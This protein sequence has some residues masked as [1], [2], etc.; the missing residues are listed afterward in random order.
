MIDTELSAEK[1]VPFI[2]EQHK[3]LSQSLLWKLQR[4]FFEEH[5][6]EA[7]RLGEVPHYITNNPF[8]AGA[9]AKVVIGFLK[10]CKNNAEASEEAAFKLD[11]KQPVYIVELGAGSG[12]F[13]FHFLKQFLGLLRG[14]VFSDI[15]VK[16][17]MT[18]FSERTLDYWRTHPWLQP[19]VE[20][21]LLDFA[22]FD[23]EQ[24]NEPILTHCGD[25]LSEGTVRNPLIILAN[26]FFDSI[27]QDAFYINQGYIYESLVT[28]TCPQMQ[29]DTS[30]PDLLNTVE[31]TYDH[32]PVN[33]DYYHDSDFDQILRDY[34]DS[35]EDTMLLFPCTAVRC[36]RDLAKLSNGRLLLLSADKG[37]SRKE[38]VLGRGCPQFKVHG[39]LSMMVNYHAIGQYVLNQGCAVL[40][41]AHRHKS[42][43]VSAF[44]LGLPPIAAVETNQAYVE[45]IERF[46]PDDFYNL[47][48][49]V[50][51]FYDSLTL[52]QIFAYLR[53][54]GWDANIFLGCFPTLLGLV[55]SLSKLEQQEL[56]RVILQ[57]WDTYYPIGEEK[58]LAF[59]LGMLLY[60]MA[61]YPEALDYF[62]QSLL[63]YGRDISTVYNMGMCH[64][65][66]GQL[67]TA[68][69]CIDQVLALD[70]ELKTTW[71]MRT[72]IQAEIERH[73]HQ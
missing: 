46:G 60:G 22:R 40:Q 51:K 35:L 38:D 29:S 72:K 63:L 14:S 5:G 32:R 10:D 21:G 15:P 64:Y 31:I 6:I 47:K 3:R 54:S 71:D 27:P 53:L 30:D 55:D 9:Y 24:D 34:V 11:H 59:S 73:N 16:Y 26:Y 43:N 67:E 48:K 57:V 61:Y 69:A 56:Y 23:C 62:E 39:S 45:A 4:T 41:T 1:N 58:D 18:D 20:Q 2:L 42:L 52:P 8:I 12:R 37:Y 28:L 13:A 49:G 17:V 36:I 25:I 70:P 33:G 19:F 7:W 50:E 68:L 44:T 65:N 66:L